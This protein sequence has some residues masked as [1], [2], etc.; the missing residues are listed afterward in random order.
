[1]SQPVWLPYYLGFGLVD[2]VEDE[3]KEYW[4]RHWVG[5]IT[6]VVLEVGEVYL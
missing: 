3:E 2:A 5:S 6:V 4:W 1:V